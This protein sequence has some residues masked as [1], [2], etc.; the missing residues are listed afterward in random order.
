MENW[1]L[2]EEWM[3]VV[4]EAMESDVTK[5]DFRQW[6]ESQRPRFTNGVDNTNKN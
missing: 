6:L 4:L 5:D 1:Y 3:T 2:D